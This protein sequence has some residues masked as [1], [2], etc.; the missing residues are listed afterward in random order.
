MR[1][2]L[3]VLA[4][5]SA[6]LPV[7]ALAVAYLAGPATAQ[8]GDRG[9][10][11]E[12]TI[13]APWAQEGDDDE[14]DDPEAAVGLCRSAPFTTTGG[15]AATSDI[16][17]ITNDP[18]NNSGSSNLG[19]QA[20][21]NE[22]AI[23]VDPSNPKHLVAGANDYRVCCDSAGL[24][25]GTG[26]AY[27]TVDGGRTWKNVQVPGLTV[28]TG[29][30]GA[31]S[32]VDSAGDPAL[33]IGPDG[34]VYYANI[35]FSRSAPTSGIAV[36]VSHDGGLT[37]DAPN[38]VAFDNAGNFF[39]DKEF[40]A[41]GPNGKVV[42]TWTR[43]SLGAQGAGYKASPIVMALSRDHGHTWNRQGSPVSDSA[44][45]YDQGSYPQFGPDGALYVA[46]EGG[47]PST[48]YATDAT[49]VARSTDD[50]LTFSNVEVGRV[51]DDLDCFPMYAGRQTLTGEHFRLNSYPTFS[52]DPV[53]GELA[54]AW[55]DDQG[56]GNCGSG[57]T[58]FSGTT[59]AQVRLVTGAWG[60]LSAPTTVT[61]GA[62]DKVFPAIASYHGVVTVSYYTRDYAATHNPAVCDVA[63]GNGPGTVVVHTTSS[64]CLDYA[65]RSSVDGFASERR[66]T[67]EGSN[68][69]IEFADG[70]FIG[71]YTQAATGSDGVFHTVWTDFRGRPG[72]TNANQDVYA[73]NFRP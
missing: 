59:S 65:A 49:I 6:V 57:T 20:P 29:G 60:A 52:V 70:S 44:H 14:I 8:D 39:N 3:R 7:G 66:L 46:Y 1:R 18:V 10:K 64:V 34:T 13:N 23:A 53:T 30:Q 51:Y 61:R 27:V 9:W 2:K 26:W 4:A 5:A 50:G 42:V 54:V 22:T 69:Y 32:Q 45:P 58:S 25:D 33:A 43:F 62:G 55:A 67:S 68:P 19:C 56:A 24:N 73:A 21:Q 40:I 47:Q 12:P 15:Y 36:S 31:F 48:G 41:A 37:W 35:V 71:D 72:V 11:F 17:V 28:E 38:M 16:D 63:T